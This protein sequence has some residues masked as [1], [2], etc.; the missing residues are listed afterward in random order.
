MSIIG[1]HDNNGTV[2]PSTSG[3]RRHGQGVGARTHCIISNTHS[4]GTG[5]VNKMFVAN[6]VVLLFIILLLLLLLLLL[7]VTAATP[8]AAALTAPDSELIRFPL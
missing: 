2:S 1:G 5:N 3:T 6:V 7:L 4:N 8:P